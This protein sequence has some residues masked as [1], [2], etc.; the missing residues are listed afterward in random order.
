M[1]SEE[2][3]EIVSAGMMQVDA[4]GNFHPNVSLTSVD[5]AAG[6]RK[7]IEHGAPLQND[8]IEAELAKL[9][10]VKD[11]EITRAKVAVLLHAI[12]KLPK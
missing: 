11:K 8:V 3:L 7:L 6:F 9:E 10:S 1:K 5:A 2:V 12:L 4:K